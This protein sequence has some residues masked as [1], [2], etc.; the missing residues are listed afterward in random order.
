MNPTEVA[1]LIELAQ[2]Y[3]DVDAEPAVGVEQVTMTQFS[4]INPFSM[5]K[6]SSER[7]VIFRPVGAMP[8]QPSW[9]TV[10]IMLSQPVTA[11]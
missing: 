7:M 10:W 1:G 11:A 5:R 8:G 6:K 3:E 4:V 9:V 2:A